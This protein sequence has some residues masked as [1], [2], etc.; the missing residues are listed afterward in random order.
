MVQRF[1]GWRGAGGVFPL[2]RFGDEIVA[3][4]C[5]HSARNRLEV[6]LLAARQA[7]L[8]YSQQANILPARCERLRSLF[9]ETRRND[10]LKSIPGGC[11]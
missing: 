11:R 6:Y 7:Q 10:D 2:I 3:R 5:E 8:T 9:V 1:G 4:L